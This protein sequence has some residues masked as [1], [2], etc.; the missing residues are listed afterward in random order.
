MT[1]SSRTFPPKK[2]PQEGLEEAFLRP[3][4]GAGR[5][6]ACCIASAFFSPSVG[7]WALAPAR[8]V[9]SCLPWLQFA[10]SERAEKLLRLSL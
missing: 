8:D 9:P 7:G 4:A 10:L 2:G 1:G 3:E 6:F 5:V